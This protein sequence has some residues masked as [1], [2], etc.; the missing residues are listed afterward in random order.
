MLLFLPTIYPVTSH[1][2]HV[3]PGSIFVAIKGYKTD[4]VLFIEQAI[5][6]GAKTIVIQNDVQ[7]S[8]ELMLLLEMHSIHL[9][10][11][12]DPRLALAELSA[13]AAGYPA[14]KLKIIG[15]TGTKGKTTTS[16]L[17]A[18]ILQHAG[19]K[20]ALLSTVYNRIGNQQFKAPLTTAQP[21]Y[22]HQFLALCVQA[23]V[24]YVVMEVAA[25]AFSLQRVAGIEFDGAIFTN[26]SQE[27]GEFYSSMDDY[28]A[29]KE[30]LF[31][32][33]KI[34]HPKIINHD[35]ARCAHLELKYAVTTISFIDASVDFCA[36]QNNQHTY[37]D[38]AVHSE[39]YESKQLVGN[40]NGY[41]A[42]CVIALGKM[43]G[44]Q[45]H[46]IQ[47]GLRIFD[48]V[49]GRMEQYQLSNGVR[50]II[51]YAH[52]PSS[53]TQILTTLKQMA[54]FVTVVFG[55]GGER[56]KTKRPIMGDIASTIADRIILTTDNPRS[57]QPHEIITDILLGVKDE[58]RHKVLIEID[59][60][61]AIKMAYAITPQEG[62]FC[63]LGK[64]PDE[65]QEVGGTKYPF[66][67]KSILKQL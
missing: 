42:L 16:F 62:T 67:E 24:E 15:I 29:A 61:K 50:A 59:R 34:G 3:G 25:Q 21:D 6:R 36:R 28:F 23:Q 19:Y 53:F 22:L 56:D 63:L 32:Q 20:T 45:P 39:Q 65:Y 7:L 33:T 38:F 5:E 60:E 26:F 12:S 66:S 30:Q 1:T 9:E 48:T 31:M 46:I 17:L 49:P 40:F 4:G 14:K 64:G 11:Y 51:D 18:H 35:N 52:N 41:N 57:E 44:L 58:H 43:L 27:H 37:V 8:P 13:Q 2:Q 10:R 47:E 54:P 55:C